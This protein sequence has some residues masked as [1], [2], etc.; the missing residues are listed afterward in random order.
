MVSFTVKS[1]G[2]W[3]FKDEGHEPVVDHFGEINKR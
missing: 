1:L 3:S 2:W